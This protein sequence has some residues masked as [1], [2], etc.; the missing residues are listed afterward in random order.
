MDT[1]MWKLRQKRLT[2]TVWET[3]CNNVV[4][5][6]GKNPDDA[7][8]TWCPACGDLIVFP[9]SKKLKKTKRFRFLFA[10]LTMIFLAVAPLCP[11]DD[12]VI[13]EWKG[14]KGQDCYS[15]MQPG[16]S[17]PSNIY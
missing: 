9:K 14:D 13:R 8:Y 11:E 17:D 15:T 7:G 6:P 12:Y 3:S 4:A 2:K 16:C 10:A 5:V 1:C